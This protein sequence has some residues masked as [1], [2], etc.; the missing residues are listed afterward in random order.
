MALKPQIF[1]FVL[2][3]FTGRLAAQIYS[4]TFDFYNQHSLHQVPTKGNKKG[5]EAFHYFKNNE[6]GEPTNPGY[7]LFGNQLKLAINNQRQRTQ[8]GLLVDYPFGGSFEDIKLFPI[9]QFN[10]KTQ[11]NQWILGSLESATKHR[12]LEPLYNYESRITR[13]VE[14]GFQ[15]LTER[16]HLSADIW[17]DWRQMVKSS[18]SQQEIISFGQ[19]IEPYLFKRQ[20]SNQFQISIPFSSLVYHRGGESL[21]QRKPVINQWNASIGLRFSL[22]K[23]GLI[24]SHIL[25]SDDF[26]PNNMRIY[27]RGWASFS[28][29]YLNSPQ[30][31]HALSLS[32]FFGQKYTAPFAPNMFVSEPFDNTLPGNRLNAG[33]RNL[34]MLRYQYMK[35]LTSSE[36]Q[37]LEFRLEPVYH[38]NLSKFAWSAGLYLHYQL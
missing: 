2:F 4:H 32:H 22:Q 30:K 5:V 6:W 14:Y 28:N 17:L 31:S 10:Y 35:N 27:N 7:T 3:A 38:I 1:I 12:L 15:Y 8:L 37:W 20:D 11:K 29:I 33:R 21:A 24:E 13:P 9:L 18:I 19:N 36:N 16:K 34:V 25:I 23:L 26:S